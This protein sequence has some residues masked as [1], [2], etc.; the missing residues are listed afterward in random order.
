MQEGQRGDFDMKAHIGMHAESGLA[1]SV[2]GISGVVNDV[3]EATS[4]LD[5]QETD[6]LPYHA[7]AG[8]GAV[9]RE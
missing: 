6:G 9:A 8:Q 1:H 5:G 7:S 3:M 4:L 2:R